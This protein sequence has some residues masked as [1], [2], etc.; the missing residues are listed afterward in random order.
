MVPT[1]KETPALVVVGLGYVG[2]PLVEA[3]VGA[4]LR[5][6]GLDV[7]RVKVEALR[8]GRSPVD[9]LSDERLGT[10]HEPQR[11]RRWSGPSWRGPG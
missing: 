10:L 1:V 9:D 5:V 6:T 7:H 8:A 2:L 4:G 3:A 11:P